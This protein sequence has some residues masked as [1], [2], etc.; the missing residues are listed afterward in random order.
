LDRSIVSIPNA[1]VAEA[2]L[3]NL[4]LRDQ[5]WVH[6]VFNLQ[7][8]TPHD[9]VRTLL[10]QITEI[11]SGHTYIDK[12]STRARLIKLTASGPQIEIFAYYRRPGEDWAAFLVQQEGLVLNVMRTI[13]AA[14]ASLASPLGALRIE[15]S[16]DANPPTPQ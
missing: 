15:T 10:D 11:L 6:Q 1:K 3:K 8:D 7:F 4:Q 9:V 5:F 12:S 14:G 13:E 2:S 16:N